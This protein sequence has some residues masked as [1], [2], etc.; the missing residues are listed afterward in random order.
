MASRPAI[1]APP[2]ERVSRDAARATAHKRGVALQRWVTRMVR[3]RPQSVSETLQL[4]Q[5]PAVYVEASSGVESG[6]NDAARIVAM[7]AFR[8]LTSDVDGQRTP[9]EAV[10]ELIS[11]CNQKN[12]EQ[13][14]KSMLVDL[15]KLEPSPYVPTASFASPQ[16]RWATTSDMAARTLID[17]TRRVVVKAYPLSATI[18]QYMGK[19]R[20]AYALVDLANDMVLSSYLNALVLDFERVVTPHFAFIIDWIA[21][22]EIDGDGLAVTRTNPNEPARITD[23]RFVP[24]SLAQYVVVERADVTLGSLLDKGGLTLRLLRAILFSAFYSLDAAW[25]VRRYLHYDF[26]GG[27]VMVRALGAELDSPFLGRVWAYKRAGDPHYFY[28]TAAEHGDLF[29]EIIDAG[30][31]RMYVPHTPGFVLIGNPNF[32]DSG[33]FVDDARADR[34]WDVRRIALDLLTSVDPDAL[35]ARSLGGTETATVK[36]AQR[37]VAKTEADA[38][39]KD[40]KEFV[41]AALGGIGLLVEAVVSANTQVKK[42]RLPVF[43]KT[44]WAAAAAAVLSIRGQVSAAT[45]FDILAPVFRGASSIPGFDGSRIFDA[46]VAPLFLAQVRVGATKVSLSA[47]SMLDHALFAPLRAPH[48]SETDRANALVV[49]YVSERDVIVDS[50]GG[51]A[52]PDNMELSRTCTFCGSGAHGIDVLDKAMYCGT[53]C[54]LAAH[55]KLNE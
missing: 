37:K 11:A 36:P 29:V 45:V 28:L 3:N 43:A 30:R 27:N 53:D 9:E 44:F 32:E 5:D 17:N 39:A 55:N 26:H 41:I 19:S 21:G 33:S 4:V 47:G 23:V 25:N 38:L 51:A 8:F 40:F 18:Q 31:S 16:L 15:Y 35:T 24:N 22:P 20:N 42:S 14:V 50:L 1:L 52:S 13:L 7:A 12:H 2:K 34:S 10:G 46:I 49:G 54:L 6:K 48:V